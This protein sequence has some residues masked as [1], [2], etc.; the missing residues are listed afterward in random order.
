[1]AGPGRTVGY[2]G[3]GIEGRAGVPEGEA[4]LPGE[5]SPGGRRAR[6]WGLASRMPS[7]EDGRHSPRA[8]A[9]SPLPSMTSTTLLQKRGATLRENAGLKFESSPPAAY[10]PLRKRLPSVWS[11]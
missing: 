9:V 8:E 2:G 6:L 7:G 1:M 11:S 10:S 3:G 4:G 5:G